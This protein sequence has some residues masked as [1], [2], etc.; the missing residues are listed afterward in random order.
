MQY[1]GVDLRPL[2]LLCFPRHR[3]FSIRATHPRRPLV[4]HDSLRVRDQRRRRDVFIVGVHA[5][6]GIA[7]RVG[8]IRPVLACL[9]LAA[10][11]MHLDNQT[12]VVEGYILRQKLFHHLVR[13][14]HLSQVFDDKPHWRIVAE[15]PILTF[16]PEVVLMQ[17]HSERHRL[18]A[19]LFEDMF[20]AA[21]KRLGEL[22]LLARG[23]SGGAVGC[24]RP[25]GRVE[26]GGL[27]SIAERLPGADYRSRRHGWSDLGQ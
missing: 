22:S 2:L 27:L 6:L 15:A 12:A 9:V 1:N 3:S 24:M 13:H 18:P 20:R 14:R 16:K 23:L 8:R 26:L 5:E 17:V 21:Y 25:L 7:A 19:V 10:V 4:A 11:V